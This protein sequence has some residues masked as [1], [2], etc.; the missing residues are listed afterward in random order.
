MT[1]GLRAELE[2]DRPYLVITTDFAELP[3][4]PHGGA[5]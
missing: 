5:G 3:T 4:A 1:T 2:H